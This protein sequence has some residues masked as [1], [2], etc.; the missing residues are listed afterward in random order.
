MPLCYNKNIITY[1]IKLNQSNRLEDPE[2]GRGVALLFFYFGVRMGGW[3]SPSPR[4]FTHG[5]DPVPIVQEAGWAPGPVWTCGKI[6]P[7]TGIRSPDR[8]ARSQSIKLNTVKYYICAQ[9]SM[10]SVHLVYYYSQI[11]KRTYNFAARIADG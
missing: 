4:R 1:N 11:Q 2:G 9:T 3:S 8:P 6:S 5:K 10:F 7:P